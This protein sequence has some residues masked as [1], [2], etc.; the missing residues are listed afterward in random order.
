MS[1][2]KQKAAPLQA[3][4]GMHDI[5][6]DTQPL[7]DKVR[8]ELK[9]LADA[10][11]FQRI[12]TPL[13]EPAE[14]FERSVGSDSDVVEKQMF[15]LAARE[16]RFVLRPEGTAPV[17]RAYIQHGMAQLMQPVKLWY[18]GLMFR[19]EQP[20]AGRFREF[21]QAGFEI[22]SSEND[23]LYD[24]QMILVSYRFLERVKIKDAT[25]LI[26]TIGCRSCRPSYRKELAEYYREKVKQLCTDCLR[27]LKMNPLRLLDCKEEGCVALKKEVPVIID[28]L[29][30]ACHDHYKAVLEYVEEL[31]IPYMLDHHLVRGFDYY[32]KTVFEL[33]AANAPSSLGGG[34]RY[35]DLVELLGGKPTPA[36]G[37]ALGLERII[38]VM[39]ERNVSLGGRQ[40]PRAFLIAIGAL[41]K[42]KSLSLLEEFRA[43]GI[44]VSETLGK[45]SLK[46]QLRSADRLNASLALIFGQ[47]EAFEETMIVR[48]LKTGVQE[49]VP[50]KKVVESAKK[51]LKAA[52]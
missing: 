26:N 34:G 19:Y 20:Q 10:Y 50:L 35:D 12:D 33:T 27:R 21:H 6:P 39:R 48:D 45:D 36:V 18:E 46:A 9:E 51:Y 28:Y 32:T 13:V 47:R 41:A 30:K 52:E 2:G 14:L 42:K 24:A 22:L 31:K 15:A 1:S 23:P 7:W 25:V 8:K 3:P 37:V 38:G 5:L 16:K 44:D 43:G 4:K 17:A 29:C 40:K 49:T 11:Q